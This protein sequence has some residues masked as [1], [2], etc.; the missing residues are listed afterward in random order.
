MYC[1]KRRT[2]PWVTLLLKFTTGNTGYFAGGEPINCPKAIGL[3]PT[4]TV[5]VT[6]FVA[7]S[8]T[9]I[10]LSLLFAT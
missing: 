6:V 2:E 1:T 4:V 5:V 3:S 8:I 10:V 9:E 7:M